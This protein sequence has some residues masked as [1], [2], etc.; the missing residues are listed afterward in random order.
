MTHP[1][2]DHKK[3]D[4]I[5]G[6]EFGKLGIKDQQ[7][8][9]FLFEWDR[10]LRVGDIR[11]YLKFPHSTLNSVIKRLE[12]KKFLDWEEYGQVKINPGGRKMVAHHLKHH[13]TIHHFFQQALG[14]TEE[15]A[16]VEG[17]KSAGI[18]SCRTVQLMKEKIPNC[19]LDGC[20][21][22]YSPQVS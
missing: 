3:D 17:L 8:L 2:V 7:V 16:H 4:E 6:E 5:L 1:M 14:L 20:G 18:L 21:I 13:I 22:I 12:S 9:I 11:N 15:E 10:P 19:D